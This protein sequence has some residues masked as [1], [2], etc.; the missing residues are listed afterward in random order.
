MAAPDTLLQ[1]AGNSATEIAQRFI[2][3]DTYEHSKNAVFAQ[4]V[5]VQEHEINRC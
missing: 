3:T 4:T 2:N 1:K 5:T